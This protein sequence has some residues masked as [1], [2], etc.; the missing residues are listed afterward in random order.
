MAKLPIKNKAQLKLEEALNKL[1]EEGK[2]KKKKD[3]KTTTKPNTK[4]HKS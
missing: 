2:L 4:P 3:G 1:K